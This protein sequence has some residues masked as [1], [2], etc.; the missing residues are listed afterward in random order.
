MY[1]CAGCYKDLMGT[2][3][4]FNKNRAFVCPFCGLGQI[5]QARNE[6]LSG[7]APTRNYPEEYLEN[8]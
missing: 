3:I 1:E 8:Q 5:I 7:K 4:T 6:T 2:G